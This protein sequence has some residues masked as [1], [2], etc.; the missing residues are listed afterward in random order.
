MIRKIF[1]HRMAWQLQ[2][3]I[4][5]VRERRNPLTVWLRRDIKKALYVNWETD[6]G[7]MHYRLTNKANR[8]SSRSSKYTGGSATF[9]KTKAR[10]VCNLFYFIINFILSLTFNVIIT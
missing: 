4:E 9:M 1:D 8:E 6:E 10:L 3:M 5:D 2:Q 7:F